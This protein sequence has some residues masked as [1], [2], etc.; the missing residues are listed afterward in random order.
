[1]VDV[2]SKAI[3]T[4]NMQ[5]I[6]NKN[7]F[8]ENRIS[9]LL[10]VLEIPFQFQVKVLSGKPDF[11]IACYNAIIFTNGCFWHR[12][13]CH[14]FKLPKTNLD[15]W[16]NKINNNYSRDMRNMLALIHQGWKVLIIWE[17]ALKGKHKL[18][19]YQLI[20][21]IEEWLCSHEQCA[22]IDTKGL[23]KLNITIY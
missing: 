15:F 2:H 5:A 14:Q 17:C 20:E 1:M 6:K 18:T 3:R 23:K 19:D 13:N 21:R 10:K 16:K 4:K 12:H 8:I 9:H 11:V 22:E 7:T